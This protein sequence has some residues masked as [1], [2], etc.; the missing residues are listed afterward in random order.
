MPSTSEQDVER[1]REFLD[2]C[3]AQ[4][5]TLL[6]SCRSCL[7]KHDDHAREIATLTETFQNLYTTEKNYPYCPE[8]QRIDCVAQF[9]QWQTF[10]KDQ[11]RVFE[12]DFLHTISHEFEDMHALI[13]LLDRRQQAQVR[14]DKTNAK[15]AT[16]KS[17]AQLTDK[18]QVT[19]AEEEKNLTTHKSY[20]DLAT[21]ILLMQEASQVWTEKV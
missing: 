20:L 8:P 12:L 9:E 14:Y 21:K 2:K 3:K 11:T 4:L 10:E 7:S 18:Q 1:L 5:E 6:D 15:V 13:E 16:L 17:K 19:L